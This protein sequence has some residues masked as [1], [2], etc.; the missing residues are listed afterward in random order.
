MKYQNKRYAVVDKPSPEVALYFDKVYCLDGSIKSVFPTASQFLTPDV[1]IEIPGFILD[2]HETLE[3]KNWD[4][5][6]IITE[7]AA[8]LVNEN[9]HTGVKVDF[10]SL[11]NFIEKNEIHN[12]VDFKK[13]I[14]FEDKNLEEGIDFERLLKNLLIA[15]T[16][17]HNREKGLYVVPLF[18]YDDSV[19]WLSGNNLKEGIELALLDLPIV[20]GKDIEWRHVREVR[21]DETS[22]KHLRDLRLFL[23]GIEKDKGKYYVQDFL[24]QKIDNYEIAAKKHGF[25]LKKEP[26]KALIGLE[27]IP[28][29]IAYGIFSF[30]DPTLIPLLGALSLNEFGGAIKEVEAPYHLH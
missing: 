11:R 10:D 12:I 4:F 14:I 2:T 27:H 24:L 26:V 13:S 20:D 16:T 9:F 25:E 8:I 3:V 5:K 28:K 7:K 29:L 17:N 15:S 1:S 21:E 23:D 19:N 6:K 30:I 18:D 22:I